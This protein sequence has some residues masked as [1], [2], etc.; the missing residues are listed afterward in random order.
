MAL[1]AIAAVVLGTLVGLCLNGA[2]IR[3]SGTPLVTT[4]PP[5]A[6]NR[7]KRLWL[8]LV[9]G[10]LFGAMTA[11]LGLSWA[12]PAY[13]FFSAVSVLLTVID[14]GYQRLPNVIVGWSAVATLVLLTLGAVG[15]DNFPALQ[16]A[17]VGAVLLF[18][19]YL[20]LAL[21]SPSGIGMGDVKLAGVVGAFLAYL[22]WR[23]LVIGA[24]GAFL[25]GA[26]VALVLLIAR[27]ADRRTLIPF[28]PS[29]LAAGVV[30]VLL[31]SG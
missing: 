13:L 26:L 20:M 1:L 7:L 11:R 10:I 3:I 9:V 19:L 31:V 2:A 5:G 29:M 22:S 8:A 21:I 27:R 24:A 16:R 15:N 6:K 25:L 18:S 30:A 28:G 4:L 12:L 23:A 14:I 17:I